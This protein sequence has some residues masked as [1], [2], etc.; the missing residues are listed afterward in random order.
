MA[1][2]STGCG[3]RLD[4]AFEESSASLSLLSELLSRSLRGGGAESC[5][6]DCCAD[7]GSIVDMA[8]ERKS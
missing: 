6:S 3:S 7:S 8:A 1:S 2:H 4:A 5:D